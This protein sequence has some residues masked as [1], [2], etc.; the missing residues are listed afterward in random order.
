MTESQQQELDPKQEKPVLPLPNNDQNTSSSLG[1]WN[2]ALGLWQRVS[3][4]PHNQRVQTITIVTVSLVAVQVSLLLTVI[5]LAQFFN[6]GRNK[7]GFYFGLK[8]QSAEKTS[9]VNDKASTTTSQVPLTYIVVDSAT[10]FQNSGILVKKGERVILEPRGRIHLSLE[11]AY[12]SA[13]AVKPTIIQYGDKQRLEETKG[14][15]W[16]QKQQEWIKQPTQQEAL[17]TSNVFYRGWI[18]P[19]GEL[20]GSEFFNEC[21][22]LQGAPWGALLVTVMPEQL[23]PQDGQADPLGILNRYRESHN[24]KLE[25]LKPVA[26]LVN[27]EFIAERDGYLT[28]IVND[29]VLSPFYLSSKEDSQSKVYYDALNEALKRS[30]GGQGR[31]PD[32]KFSP[33]VLY[34][35]NLGVFHVTIKK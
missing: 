11:Q 2:I 33:L 9:T 3:A 14:K 10:G 23:S 22:L 15:E 7:D 5:V 32:R 16:L 34:A 31:N 4:L 30:S 28:F 6:F 18:G 25:E 12:N 26:Q 24:L 27:Q 13:R 1:A 19:E 29:A 8:D 35:D 21:L 20:E 17:E